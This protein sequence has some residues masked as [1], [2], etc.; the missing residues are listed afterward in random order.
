RGAGKSTPHACLEENITLDLINDTE[1]LREY[2]EIPEWQIFGGSW[3][4]NF[5][6]NT[7]SCTQI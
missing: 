3:E 2:L 5:P 7:A 6:L 1:K 4:I